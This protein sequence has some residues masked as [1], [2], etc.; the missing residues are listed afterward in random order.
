M[1]RSARKRSRTRGEL[2]LGALLQRAAKAFG[3]LSP[4]RQRAD[5]VEREADLAAALNEIQA[6]Q[7]GRVIEPLAAL[8]PP[9]GATGRWTRSS[10]AWVR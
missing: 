3:L 2:R 5:V 10:A 6:L 1:R 9:R 7:R 8:A 4:V